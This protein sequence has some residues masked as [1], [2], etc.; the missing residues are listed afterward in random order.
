[1]STFCGAS[2]LT[3]LWIFPKGKTSRLCDSLDWTESF[4]G[5]GINPVQI[6]TLLSARSRWHNWGC[7][8]GRRQ[9]C[10]TTAACIEWAACR[11]AAVNECPTSSPCPRPPH[12]KYLISRWVSK[13]RKERCYAGRGRAAER[14]TQTLDAWRRVDRRPVLWG[15][16]SR[17]TVM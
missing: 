4:S 12:R 2:L 7:H 10:E 13:S 11:P 16:Q 1:M 14:W 6:I 8:K 9:Q 15:H 5:T 17:Q 3:N